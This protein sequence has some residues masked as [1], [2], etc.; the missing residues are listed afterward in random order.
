MTTTN[1]WMQLLHMLRLLWPSHQRGCTG[2]YVM[3]THH[4]RDINILKLHPLPEK[5]GLGSRL[6][7][8]SAQWNTHLRFVCF[9]DLDSNCFHFPGHASLITIGWK[10][11]RTDRGSSYAPCMC[12]HLRRNFVKFSFIDFHARNKKS[13]IYSVRSFDLK[14]DAKQTTG[15]KKNSWINIGF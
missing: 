9:R 6:C 5:I 1:T 2:Y 7:R 4:A 15:C 10:W 12:N 14:F 13:E 3:H 8:F 11:P